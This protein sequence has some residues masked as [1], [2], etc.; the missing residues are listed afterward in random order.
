MH[1]YLATVHIGTR[2]FGPCRLMAA[3]VQQFQV[4]RAFSITGCPHGTSTL[5]SATLQQSA[6]AG[7]WAQG[8]TQ[9]VP[10]FATCAAILMHYALVSAPTALPAL[11]SAACRTTPSSVPA[12]PWASKLATASF[13]DA[14]GT[15]PVSSPSLNHTMYCIVTTL[16]LQ[17]A[18]PLA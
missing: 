14:E 16:E 1:P 15:S 17:T 5:K 2:A 3:H 9:R 4:H 7:A 12:S 18:A 10:L 11:D 13:A 8:V 6:R